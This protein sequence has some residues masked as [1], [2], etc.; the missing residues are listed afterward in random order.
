MLSHPTAPPAG[1]GEG[2]CSPGAAPPRQRLSHSNRHIPK[3]RTASP[4]SQAKQSMFST[5]RQLPP[6]HAAG[7]LL[8]FLWC[9]AVLPQGPSVPFLPS[10]T[11]QLRG[12][13]EAN[14][15][16]PGQHAQAVWE[17]DKC[18]SVILSEQICQMPA[19]FYTARLAQFYFCLMLVTQIQVN[20]KLSCMCCYSEFPA[21]DPSGMK[22]LNKTLPRLFRDIFS[23]FTFCL[24][25]PFE[26][27]LLVK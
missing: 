25:R 19:S 15:A 13:L 9:F 22:V 14:P 16:R 2:G 12:E 26:P 5:S 11:E 7:R 4:K 20:S 10:Q 18:T 17:K 27:K 1:P 3:Q 6:R 24:S 21:S 8:L 23:T